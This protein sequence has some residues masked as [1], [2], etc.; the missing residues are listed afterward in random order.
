M[1][2]QLYNSTNFYSGR[3]KAD[4]PLGI[5]VRRQR[6]RR[7]KMSD[8]R[9]ARLDALKFDWVIDPDEAWEANFQELVKY[10]AANGNCNVN[11]R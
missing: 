9:K 3:Y 8:T 1:I 7:E 6:V 5:W 4:P 11:F 10:Q 2:D